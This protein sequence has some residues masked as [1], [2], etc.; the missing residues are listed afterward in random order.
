MRGPNQKCF[1][2]NQIT[3]IQNPSLAHR[4]KAPQSKMGHTAQMSHHHAQHRS[5]VL[6]EARHELEPIYMKLRRKENLYINHIK[7][8]RLCLLG[9][10][11]MNHQETQ[12]GT[13]S[14]VI[15][16]FQVLSMIFV[17]WVQTVS[18]QTQ[19]KLQTLFHVTCNSKIW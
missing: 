15:H 8:K 2:P 14:A 12:E 16:V 11:G 13:L 10:R 5:T 6:K 17:I 19:P 4:H 7:R 18:C 1:T 3:L 9:A